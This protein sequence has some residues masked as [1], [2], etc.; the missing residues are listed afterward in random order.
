MNHL[1]EW[2]VGCLAGAVALGLAHGA[3]KGRASGAN[4]EELPHESLK[5]LTDWPAFMRQHDTTFDK[6]PAGWTEAPHFGNAMVGSMLYQ[7]GNTLK[8]QVFRA[9]VHDHRDDTWGWTAY[10][11]PRL[12]IGHFS[13]HPVGMLTGCQW[14]TGFVECRTDRNDHD[15][16]RK[17]PHPSFHPRGGH[18]DRHRTRLRRRARKTAHGRGIRLRRG[19]RAAA[20]QPPSPGSQSSRSNTARTTKGH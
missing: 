3:E 19:R 9:D 20:I 1:S 4:G 8:L 18:G 13:L 17:D 10:S 7:D 5:P 6:L 12:Q 15:R 16:P 2:A 11:R 14:R